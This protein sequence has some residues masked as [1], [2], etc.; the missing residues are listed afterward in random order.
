MKRCSWVRLIVRGW[1]GIAGLLVSCARNTS[2]DG[3]RTVPKQNAAVT[4]RTL[5]ERSTRPAFS[6]FESYQAALSSL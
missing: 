4:R 1:G 6:K 5:A 2:S 3:R